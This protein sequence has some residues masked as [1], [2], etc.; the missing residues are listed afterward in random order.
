MAVRLP[1]WAA[2]L[3]IK[4]ILAIQD[5]KVEPY[6][7]ERTHRRAVARLIEIVDQQYPRDRDGYLTVMHAGVPEQGSGAGK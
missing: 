3:Q 6:E 1:W 2:C 7:K 5:G 4:P